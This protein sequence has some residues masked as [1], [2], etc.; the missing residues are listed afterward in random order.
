MRERKSSEPGA[1]VEG[2]SY[3]R[4]STP[5]WLG[6][7]PLGRYWTRAR[8][9]CFRVDA[10]L[11][12]AT[13]RQE[14][15]GRAIAATSTFWMLL[16]A[17][18]GINGFFPD[19]HFAATAG[20]GTAARNMWLFKTVYPI[21]HNTQAPL[22]GSPYYMHH[23]LGDFWV[24][25]IFLKIFGEHNWVLRLPAVLYSTLSV[26]LVY[27]IGRA[28]WGPLPGALAA[29]AYASLP[30]TMGFSN[31]HALEN[32][33]IFGCLLSSWG[34][35]RFVQ[36]ARGRFAAVSIVGLLWAVNHDWAP[37]LWAIA[38]VGWLFVRGFVVS[39][40]WFGPLPLRAFGRYWGLMCGAA[41]LSLAVTMALII[42]SGKL[43]ELLGMYGSRASGNGTPIRQVLAA[44]HV[45]IAFM[46][47]GLAIVLGKL[48][49]PVIIA[50]VFIRRNE[51]EILPLPILLM[52]IVQYLHFKQGADIHIF[53]PHYFAP[54]FALGIGALTAS[55]TELL[56]W[57]QT[58]WPPRQRW[59]HRLTAQ[60]SPPWAAAAV[61]ALPLLLIG[62]DGASMNRLAHET[63][64]RF[65]SSMIQSDLDKVAALRWF[66]PQLRPTDK[67]AFHSPLTVHWALD[68]DLRPHVLVPGQPVSSGAAVARVLFV[69]TRYA[70]AADLRDAAK[71]GRVIAVGHY[72]IVDRA[73]PSGP[74]S[75]PPS[76]LIEGYS[77]AER[78]PRLWEWYFVDGTE[79]IRKVAADPWVTWEWRTLL[80]Q[81]APLPAGEP[82]TLEQIRV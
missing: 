37:Y 73:A 41:M 54:Y 4:A 43:S 29:F 13:P 75:G 40:D 2:A 1:A 63:G 82:Q 31:F 45:W 12:A 15:W 33:V 17:C 80:G 74:P 21:L 53:W 22:Y 57:V 61:L 8:A 38:F 69:D 67:I 26:A 71:S 16:V 27:R 5:A 50:R 18:W 36:T 56:T 11:P 65:N 3:L 81:A 20:I 58:R 42:D 35:A 66:L 64:G 14:S 77:F 10:T 62:K 23:P 60:A 70:T 59:L 55:L 28:A 32:P 78:E 49:L 51:L 7:A 47:P 24:D 52:A 48:A 9:S 79:P 46:F 6:L 44:R 76:G 72:W 19:G 39:S 34:Y 68:W 30:M 25:A